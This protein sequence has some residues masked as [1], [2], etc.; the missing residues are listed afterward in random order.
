MSNIIPIHAERAHAKLSASGSEKWMTCTPSARLEEQFPDDESEF[1][2]EGTFAHEV[3]ELAL[4]VWLERVPLEQARTQYAEL[5]ANKFWS[6]DLEDHVRAAVEKAKAAITAARERCKD[7]V[8]FVE[9]RLDFSVWVPEGFGT[10]D[11]VIIT[12]DLVEVQDLKFGKG[13]LVSAIDNSQM[14]L[15]GLGAFNEL[16]HLYDIK[17][18]RMTILQPRLDNYSSEEISAE[19]LLGWAENH[20]VPRAKLAWDGE[21]AFVAGDHCTSCFCRARFQC[22]ARASAALEV[23]KQDF[24]LKP[25]ELLSPDQITDILGKADLAIDWLNDV[26]TYALKQAE[27]GHQVPG[28][29]LVEG[30]SNRKYSDQDAVAQR[31]MSEG[32]EEAIIYERSLLGITA[33]EKALGKKRFAELLED[34]IVKPSGK[35]TLVP[36]SDKRPA[37]SSVAS[38]AEDFQ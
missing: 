33:M 17:R 30:R 6:Q 16:A 14:R 25:P 7:P 28:Y 29:K 21:G 20:V 5:K 3:F 15:Y 35:P 1:A 2:K 8:I 10:G 19:E 31:L 36:E 11:L 24:A 13:I 18:V 26:K 9:K 27:A 37:L 38:A 22:E 32:V 12:D 23:A 4:L 34:L